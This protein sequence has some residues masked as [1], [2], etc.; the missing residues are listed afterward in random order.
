MQLHTQNFNHVSAIQ[1]SCDILHH[2]SWDCECLFNFIFHLSQPHLLPATF[3]IWLTDWVH[4][5]VVLN[6]KTISFSVG[7]FR[8]SCS[9]RYLGRSRF[10]WRKHGR[11]HH[12]RRWTNSISV[13]SNWCSTAHGMYFTFALCCSGRH[14]GSTNSLRFKLYINYGV[15]DNG[16]YKS[17]NRIYSKWYL[18]FSHTCVHEMNFV[19]DAMRI[20]DHNFHA[21]KIHT[22][23]A[24]RTWPTD[25]NAWRS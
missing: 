24:D 22:I 21:L 7:S 14:N 2:S 16:A 11:R 9:A 15:C 5:S 23:D 12:Q 10:E 13:H 3:I 8:C 20:S 18:F 25:R 6:A 17:S 1:N 4:F 19:C